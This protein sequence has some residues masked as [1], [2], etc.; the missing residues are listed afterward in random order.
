MLKFEAAVAGGEWAAGYFRPHRPTE[1]V[2]LVTGCPNELAA[3]SEAIRL[4]DE[5]RARSAP[6]AEPHQFRRPA[7]G[8]YADGE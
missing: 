5:Q 4:A 6:A 7:Q 8:W 1:F 2:A 3:T